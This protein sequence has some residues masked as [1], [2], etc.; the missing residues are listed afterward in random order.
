ML[1]QRKKRTRTI[2]ERLHRIAVITGAA[3]SLSIAVLVVW[4]GARVRASST[5]SHGSCRHDWSPVAAAGYLDAREVWWQAWPEAQQGH[6]T[7]CVSCHTVLPYA[8]V[9]PALRSQI[10]EIE[11][12]ATERKMLNSIGKRVSNWSQMRPYYDDAAHAAPSRATEAVLNAVILAEYSGEQSDLRPL[13]YEAFD[14]AWALQETAGENAGGWK[15]QDFHEAPW[16]SE[17]SAYQ[18][19]AMMAIA[20]ESMPDSYRNETVVHAHVEHLWEYLLR[21]YDAQPLMNQLYVLWATNQ[22]P[23]LLRE[24]QRVALIKK[25]TALQRGDGGWSLASVDQQKRLKPAVLDLFKRANAVDGSDGI[26]TGLA[27]L[28]LEEGRVSLQD[29]VLTGGLDWLE[30]HQYEEGNWWASSLNG[31]RDP[32][33]GVGRFMSDAATGYA[34]LA[35]EQARVLQSKP[36]RQQADKLIGSNQGDDARES[37]R[38]AAN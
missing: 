35:L 5:S 20:F 3:L 1:I 21:R 10:G 34:V 29:P 26:A 18:G 23:E 16:E 30:H 7:V 2:E 17:E 38:I 28:A 33:S 19:A 25:V 22:T 32:A 27:V 36:V 37:A 13:A 9:R 15:W 24:S 31:F 11:L 6:G 14:E 4:A 8:L 12:T